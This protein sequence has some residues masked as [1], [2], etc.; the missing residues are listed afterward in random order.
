[1]LKSLYR[2]EYKY[3]K[4]AINNLMLIITLGQLVVFI[5]DL[6]FPD[7]GIISWMSLSRSA[8]FAGQVW[9]LVTFLLI[10]PQTGVLWILLSLYFYYMI[11][12]ALENEWGAFMFNIYYLIGVLGTIVAA[13]IAGGATNYYL[14]M[15][16]FF[17]FAILFPN[18]E[19]LLL[20]IIPI[21]IKYLA[22][23]DALL[24]LYSF[25]MGT[26]STR[27][28]IIAAFIN[29]I[30]FFGGSVWQKFKDNR[31]YAAAR[32]NFRSQMNEWDRN[33]RGF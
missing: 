24:F 4:Y 8:L 18:F 3:G 25:V 16:L 19:V 28:S 11:G 2:L 32:K 23:L 9:R 30:I 6:F 31:K 20:F 29:L 13:L 33:Q 26:W 10:P 17:A 15:S 21:K 27:A 1:M 12:G 7:W 14:N 5:I 22:I